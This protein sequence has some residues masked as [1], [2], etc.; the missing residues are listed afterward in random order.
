MLKSVCIFGV[1]SPPIHLRFDFKSFIS[2]VNS[3]YVCKLSL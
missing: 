2:A 1:H 3:E